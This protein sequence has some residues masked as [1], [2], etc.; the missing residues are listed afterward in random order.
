MLSNDDRILPS[1]STVLVTGVSGFLGSHIADQLLAFGYHVRGT[2]RDTAKASWMSALFAK[3]Y[4]NQ[5][6]EL[7][8]VQEMTQPGAFDDALKG[9]MATP[10]LRAG[11]PSSLTP[12]G[13]LRHLGRHPRSVR[14]ELRPGPEQGH[15][16]H[17]LRDPP[18]PQRRLIAPQSPP[19]HPHFILRSG[20]DARSGPQDSRGHLEQGRVRCCLGA[21]AV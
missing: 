15:S 10:R 11:L 12:V 8:E 17:D 19:L 18:P 16:A 2:T 5:K 13:V 14:H 6:F 7:V 4:E 1:G 9:R 20:R 3:K 21:A